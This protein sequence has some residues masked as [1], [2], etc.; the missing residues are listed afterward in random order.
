M[1]KKRLEDIGENIM[2]TKLDNGLEIIFVKKP[3]FSK[4][5]ASVVTKIGST[6]NSF[7]QGNKDIKISDGI[8]HFLEH[9]MFEKAEGD[10]FSKFSV[11]GGS[12]NAYTTFD[13]TC[14]Y[15]TCSSNFIE[16][17]KILLEMM[18]TPYYTD[19]TVEKEKGIIAE[20][21][22]MYE[23]DSS[24]VLFFETLRNLY[25]N[26]PINVDIAGTEET[27]S[28][29]T[30]EELYL[31]YNTFYHPN[32]SAIIVVGDFCEKD[33]LDTIK[34]YYNN[35][36]TKNKFTLNKVSDTLVNKTS[37]KLTMDINNTKCSVAFKQPIDIRYDYKREIAINIYLQMK[38]GKTSDNYELL[39]NQGLFP[40]YSYSELD[41]IGFAMITC[42]VTDDEV[43]Y[44]TVSDILK[45][46]IVKKDF[47]VFKNKNIGEIIRSFN[48]VDSVMKVYTDA[49]VNN[50][51]VKES[52]NE[53]KNLSYEDIVGYASQLFD[54]SN[55]TKVIISSKN[56][57]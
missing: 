5:I 1:D 24:W 17:F 30:A 27:I 33:A 15:F 11:F 14:Y 47:L 8:A 56:N 29:I 28:G 52:L 54:N 21:I 49:F 16:N 12:A 39:S 32:N 44:K 22:K 50:F 36:Q 35:I 23:D 2:V 37:T 46:P 53:I 31:C 3:G 7:V 26:H 41:N 43:F 25:K 20:E 18:T 10:V 48:T 4:T 51:D 34:L 6:N 42:D 38:F 13:H 45:Q 9:K 57:N 40:S 19:E 55:K